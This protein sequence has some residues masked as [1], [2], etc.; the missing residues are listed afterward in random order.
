MDIEPVAKIL[1]GFSEFV[2]ALILAAV[3][4][5]ASAAR[6]RPFYVGV[7]SWADCKGGVEPYQ[8]EVPKPVPMP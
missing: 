2:I 8:T 3:V 7:A 4:I 6:E 5:L 1:S